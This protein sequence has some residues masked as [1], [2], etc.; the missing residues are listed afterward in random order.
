[1]LLILLVVSWTG[2]MLFPL[3]PFARENMVSREGFS[4][5]VLRQLAH[6]P[7]SGYAESI[8]KV[9]THDIPPAFR[10]GVHLFI[11]PTAIAP[12]PNSAGPAI[13]CTDGA[14][15]RQSACTGP[16]VRKVVP[17]PGV[18]FSDIIR[19]QSMCA[20]LFSNLPQY[21]MTPQLL[22]HIQPEYGE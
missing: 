20:S 5:P 17:V 18:A 2:K 10:G 15:C 11:P 22:Q 19:N 16:V 9:L 13:M 12:V 3:S 8:W 1:M 6:S 14:H 7:H 21:C 4:H